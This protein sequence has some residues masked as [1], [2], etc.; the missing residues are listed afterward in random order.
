MESGGPLET[1]DGVWTI[2]RHL[3]DK[4]KERN[5]TL[6]ISP[7]PLILVFAFPL[8]IILAVPSGAKLRRLVSR[9]APCADVA[10]SRCILP[11]APKPGR[12]VVIAGLYPLP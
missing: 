8:P 7:Y 5:L 2:G 3:N 12:T 11:G 10:V 1:N 6:K 9:L 4:F